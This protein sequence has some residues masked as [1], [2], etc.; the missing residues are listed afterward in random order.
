LKWLKE[1]RISSEGREGGEDRF[2]TAEALR[3]QRNQFSWFVG[4]YRQTKKL[5]APIGAFLARSLRAYG[6]SAS[7]DSP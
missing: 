3:T 2:F 1:G 7:P 4:R 5:S 6:E